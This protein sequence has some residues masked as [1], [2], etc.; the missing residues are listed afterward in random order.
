MTSIEIEAHNHS[1]PYD[2]PDTKTMIQL[3]LD[4]KINLWTPNE[5][6]MLQIEEL[7]RPHGRGFGVP[8][9]EEQAHGRRGDVLFYPTYTNKI[10]CTGGWNTPPLSCEGLPVYVFMGSREDIFQY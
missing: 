6:A 8:N 3:F 7:C 4:K 1:V 9:L 2:I 10:K 5:Y